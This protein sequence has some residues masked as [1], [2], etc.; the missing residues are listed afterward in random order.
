MEGEEKDGREIGREIKRRGWL[1]RK[2]EGRGRWKELEY[3]EG[4]GGRWKESEIEEEGD[5]WGGRR[6]GLGYGVEGNEMK[7][8]G[9]GEDA[10]C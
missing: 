4:G 2:I 8:K 3:G 10:T 5:G 1:G 6:K 7:G 9:D